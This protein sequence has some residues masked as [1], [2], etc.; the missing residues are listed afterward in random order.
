MVNDKNNQLLV[1]I[2]ECNQNSKSN[3]HVKLHTLIK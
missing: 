1:N 2:F 3:T